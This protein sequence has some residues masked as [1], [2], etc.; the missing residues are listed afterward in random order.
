MSDW[1]GIRSVP[2]E[3]EA[4]GPLDEQREIHT[5]EGV[6]IAAPGD[7]LIREDDG[8]VYP[9]GPDKFAEYYEVIRGE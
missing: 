4:L 5:R 8:N 6:V 9:I 1:F 7:Y 2:T 3:K